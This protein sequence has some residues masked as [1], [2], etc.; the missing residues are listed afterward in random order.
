MLN[1]SNRTSRSLNVYISDVPLYI[2]FLVE[3][4]G[5]EEVTNRLEQVN[6]AI[7][8]ESGTYLHYWLLPNSIFWLGLQEAIRFMSRKPLLDKMPPSIERTV[9]IAAKLNILQKS[10]TQQVWN[11]L[12]AKILRSDYL[13]PIFFEIDTAA[14]FWQMGYDIEWSEPI[15]KPNSR[16]PEFS[17]TSRETKRVEVECKSKRADAGR[18]ILRSAFYKL[19]DSLAP[20]LSAEGYTGKV[21]I[22][23]P[24]RMPTKDTWKKQ[25]FNTLNQSLLSTNEQLS[26]DDGTLITVDLYRLKGIVIP[27]KKVFTEAQAAKHPYSYLAVYAREYGN[28]LTN[29]L[30]FEMK[31][32]SDDRFLQDV[33]DNLKDANRQFTGNNAALVALH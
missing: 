11:D 21:L 29:P 5:F 13:S 9:E 15:V 14:H 17:L 1:T 4:L 26:L 12:R 31:S 18:K 32:Q 8:T 2:E 10:M 16:I 7:Q 28:E 24:D 19:V 3:Y 6:R 22:V 33:F 20:S 30:V 27:A 25:V 23:V